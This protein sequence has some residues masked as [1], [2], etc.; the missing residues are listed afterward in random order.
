[1]RITTMKSSELLQL[2]SENL[3]YRDGHLYWL[4]SRGN[5]LAGD[6]AGCLE[7]NGY[8]TIKVNRKLYKEHRL[9]FLMFNPT[10]DIFDY[11]LEIDHINCERNDN[12]IENLRLVTRQE[13]AF[14][15]TKSKGYNWHKRRQKF[16]ARIKIN[17]EDKHL[18]YFDN[19]EDARSAYLKAKKELHIIKDRSL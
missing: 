1:M 7:T 8:R 19:E 14:N 2:A 15:E 18:G 6:Q 10:W 9:I 11:S 13:N 12:R 5:R 16:R 4:K 3:E 17:G